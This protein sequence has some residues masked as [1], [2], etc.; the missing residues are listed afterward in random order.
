MGM[1]VRCHGGHE[2]RTGDVQIDV[3]DCIANDLKMAVNTFFALY[4][5]FLG[6]SDDLGIVSEFA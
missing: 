5:G 6:A 3:V 4:P 2:P 1:L